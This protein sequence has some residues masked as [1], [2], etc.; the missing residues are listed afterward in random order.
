MTIMHCTWKWCLV[1]TCLAISS[2]TA[3]SSEAVTAASKDVEP[4]QGPRRRLADTKMTDEI[5]AVN[6]MLH[7]PPLLATTKTIATDGQIVTGSLQGR[8]WQCYQWQNRGFTF[9]HLMIK[10]VKTA[11]TGDPDLYVQQGSLPSEDNFLY[12][13]LGDAPVS[14]IRGADRADKWNANAQVPGAWHG[15]WFACVHNYAEVDTEYTLQ[16]ALSSC[17][18]VIS[19]LPDKS[20]KNFAECAGRGM[21]NVTAGACVCSGESAYINAPDCSAEL[22]HLP[23]GAAHVQGNLTGGQWRYYTYNVPDDDVE[24]V[25]SL[26]RIAGNGD[27][28]LYLRY[29]EVPTLDEWDARATFGN[30]PSLTLIR[31]GNDSSPKDS[32]TALRTGLWF[33]G[34]YSTAKVGAGFELDVYGYP[35]PANCSGHGACN[36]ADH[37]CKCEAGWDKLADCSAE[38]H[39]L[40]S[41]DQEGAHR[42]RVGPTSYSYFDFFVT[43]EMVLA[44]VEL[45]LRARYTM[46]ACEGGACDEV[47]GQG[48][49]SPR[50]LVVAGDQYP[51]AADSDY[52]LVLSENKWKE[53]ALPGAT[54]GGPFSCAIYNPGGVGVDVNVSLTASSPLSSTAVAA[55]GPKGRGGC[56]PELVKLR[57]V[58]GGRAV[59]VKRCVCPIEAGAMDCFIEDGCDQFFCKPGYARALDGSKSCVDERT[60]GSVSSGG[61]AATGRKVPCVPGSFRRRDLPDNSGRCV[62]AGGP[63]TLDCNFAMQCAAVQCHASFLAAGVEGNATCVPAA[64][65]S[66]VG[67]T[68]DRAEPLA[69]GGCVEDSMMVQGGPLTVPHG[70][71]MS[72]CVCTFSATGERLCRYGDLKC[73]SLHCDAGYTEKGGSCLLA[74]AGGHGGSSKHYSTV[75][76]FF[77]ALSTCVAGA[78]LGGAAIWYWASRGKYG[79]MSMYDSNASFLMPLDD[80]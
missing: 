66:G 58:D 74:A 80:M 41:T 1:V 60:L 21:C 72:K 3:I 68:E 30:A 52:T 51:T 9:H 53:L 67:G 57:E 10:L 75:G 47:A 4:L 56:D 46:Q 26:A 23:L 14:V 43:D 28:D 49:S 32:S 48:P 18:G 24:V 13:E 76:V 12:R 71:C 40:L 5:A 54:K 2:A 77:I 17:P 65:P 44:R 29:R 64:I 63:G 38:T 8:G 33:L 20:G 45:L 39:T 22:D 42:L 36:F 70:R 37:T 34:V 27:V 19:K 79:Y 25:A 11:P 31:P 59:C 7:L 35:C 78:A 62:C 50:L 55:V 61:G 69:P 15:F 16:L 6:P 73:D